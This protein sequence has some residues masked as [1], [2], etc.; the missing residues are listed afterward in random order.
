MRF[1][2]V[3]VLALLLGL[4]CP[5]SAEVFT[6]GDLVRKADLGFRL[7]VDGDS[8]VVR[9]LT[10]DSPAAKAGLKDK[11]IVLGFNGREVKQ[12]LD[13]RRLIYRYAGDAPL[14][15]KLSRDGKPLNLAFTPPP[16]PWEAMPGAD[17]YYGVLD[18][19]DGSR[20]RSLVA[21][22]AGE[23]KKMPAIFL[24]QW[25]SCSS[26]EY[27]EQSG[28]SKVQAQL[29][30][31]TGRAFIRVERSG[32]GDSEGPACHQLDYDTELE[33][34]YHAFKQL[35]DHPRIQGDNIILFGSS[36]GSTMAPLLAEKLWQD[37]I[38]VKGIM[39]Q[40]GGGV[41]YLE[42]MMSFERAY[43]ERRPEVDPASIHNEIMDRVR[44]YTQY[45]IEQRSP[46]DVAK[47]SAAMKRVFND[48]RGL[49]AR[50]QYGRP[51]AWH[52]Q[53]AQ[54]NFLKAWYTVIVPV[55]VV[56]NE[57]DQY[58]MEHGHR[59]ITDMINRWRPG[60]ATYVMQKGMGHSNYR[61]NS[62]EEAY[63]D[64]TGVAEPETFA[65]VLVKWVNGLE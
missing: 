24:V 45:F 39:V 38:K 33:H 28:G 31:E 3:T 11:D 5:L 13:D 30:R 22:P 57:F 7:A 15:L 53:A 34:Y 1:Y 55:L 37:G 25:V 21:V 9:R 56:F 50:T 18:M 51:H 17:S 23:K 61:F 41:T 54:H 59:M 65:S 52:Q 58:E 19:P 48:I 60:T 62:L 47:D 27:R 63:A 20:L 46:N 35:Q 64:E 10:A 49:D 32:D 4:V 2:P 26:L 40:G 14:K 29:L 12:P 43:L 8:L 44:F 36:L 42:R 16:R 6:T